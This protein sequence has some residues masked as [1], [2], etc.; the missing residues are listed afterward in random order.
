MP[1][2]AHARALAWFAHR[3]Q[4]DKAGAPYIEHPARV[5][6]AVR[7]RGP[8][9]AAAAWLHDVVEDTAVTVGVVRAVVGPVVADAVDA[10]T[11]RRGE[12]A[13]AYY[14][15]VLANPVAVVVK[16]ADVADNADESRLSLLD[17]STAERLRRKYERASRV[18][19]EAA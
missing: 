6:S 19:E 8:E 14:Q 18:L 2:V 9:Y 4:V 3:R 17:Q 12:S 11:R 10:L 1:V 16:R 15:R 13:D 5:A 7:A